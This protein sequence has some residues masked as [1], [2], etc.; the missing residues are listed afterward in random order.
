MSDAD[1]DQLPESIKVRVIRFKIAAK[2]FRCSQITLCTTLLDE[3]AY[4][5]EKIA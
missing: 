1:Y 4:P 5:S 2:G 3:I